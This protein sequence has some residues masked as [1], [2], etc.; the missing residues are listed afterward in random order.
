MIHTTDTERIPLVFYS[1]LTHII[2]KSATSGIYPPGRDA[3]HGYYHIIT[4]IV[5]TLATA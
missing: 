5:D 1:R 4:I 3:C 2:H